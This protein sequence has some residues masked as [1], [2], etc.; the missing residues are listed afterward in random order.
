[1]QCKSSVFMEGNQKS[2]NDAANDAMY[3]IS[4]PHISSLSLQGLWDFCRKN[5]LKSHIPLRGGIRA[6]NR[7]QNPTVKYQGGIRAQNR[8]QNPTIKYEGG[9]RAQNR[10]QNPAVWGDSGTIFEPESPSPLHST[11]I[12]EILD[13]T[14]SSTMDSDF[15]DATV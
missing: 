15:V 8:S 1:M 10:S 6:R 12:G 2:V 3:V 7:S 9:I 5:I 13:S 14:D 4:P 11:G